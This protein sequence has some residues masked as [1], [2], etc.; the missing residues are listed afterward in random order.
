ML[1][2][3][4]SVAG[5]ELAAAVSNA[6]GIGVIGGVRYMPDAMRRVI[7][8]LKSYLDSP[9]LPWGIDLLLP[10][11]GGNARATNT[12][13]TQVFWTESLVRSSFHVG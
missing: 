5:P 1:A 13:Y 3:M 8:E 6:G 2:G 12:D 11:V 10:Q 9:D 7:K 4:G